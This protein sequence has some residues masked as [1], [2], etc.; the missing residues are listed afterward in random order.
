MLLH[1][2]WCICF[3]VP[4]DICSEIQCFK[5]VFRWIWKFQFMQ[6]IK[7]QNLFFLPSQLLACWPCSSPR[8]PVAVVARS[9]STGLP[10]LLSC[11]CAVARSFSWPSWGRSPAR[12][13]A[14]S[15]SHRHWGPRHSVL[16]FLESAPSRTRMGKILSLRLRIFLRFGVPYT[17]APVQEGCPRWSALLSA[18]LAREPPSSRARTRHQN[19]SGCSRVCVRRFASSL[20]LLSL[21]RVPMCSKEAVNAFI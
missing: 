16:S 15:L 14:H 19:P 12:A 6:K 4:L 1:T 18:I 9:T 17:T 8:R 13:L 2:C 20:A 21:R 7:R 3:T 11:S 10:P 5:T